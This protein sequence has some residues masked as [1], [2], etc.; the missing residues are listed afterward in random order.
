MVNDDYASQKIC[1]LSIILISMNITMI[2]RGRKYLGFFSIFVINLFAQ[3]FF[4]V[5]LFFLYKLFTSY[6]IIYPYN[7]G[8]ASDSIQSIFKV[9]PMNE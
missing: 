5:V 6:E 7:L 3:F 9:L 8:L 2:S 4:Y 1:Y